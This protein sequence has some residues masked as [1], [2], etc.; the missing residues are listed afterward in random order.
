M[1][2]NSDHARGE[3]GEPHQKRRED[4][5]KCEH[6]VLTVGRTYAQQLKQR[7]HHGTRPRS[8]CL[9]AMMA[10]ASTQEEKGGTREI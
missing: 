2:G 5:G 4:K 9:M 7:L 3:W 8:D 10:R 6:L 1:M